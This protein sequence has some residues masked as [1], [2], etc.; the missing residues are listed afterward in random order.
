MGGCGGGR[1]R[2]VMVVGGGGCWRR[3]LCVLGVGRGRRLLCVRCFVVIVAVCG[4]LCSWA[5][6]FVV[7]VGS[8]R[9]SQHGRPSSV[10][11]CLDGGGKERSNHVTLP[12]KHCLLSMTNK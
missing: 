7:V 2:L 4:R 11:V 8:R 5:L 1:D 6:L 3:G 9:R 12:N 10:I